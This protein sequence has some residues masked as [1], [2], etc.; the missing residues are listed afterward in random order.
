L[1]RCGPVVLA[2]LNRGLMI[3]QFYLI[4]ALLTVW[5]KRAE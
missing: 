3:D 4:E 2:C 1:W 5:Q